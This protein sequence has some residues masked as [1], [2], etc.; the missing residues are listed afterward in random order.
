MFRNI[1]AKIKMLA[2]VMCIIGMI[3]SVISGII[4]ILTMVGDFNF[5]VYLISVLIIVIGCLLSWIGSFGLYGFGELIEKT[6]ANHEVN[7]KILGELK[8]QRREP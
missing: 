8:A 6:A 7:V 4:T 5:V 2:R 3:A 1:G